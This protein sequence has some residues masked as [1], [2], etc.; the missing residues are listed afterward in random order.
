M[1]KNMTKRNP[2]KNLYR[3]DKFMHKKKKNKYRKNINNKRL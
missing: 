3:K 1:H 2:I